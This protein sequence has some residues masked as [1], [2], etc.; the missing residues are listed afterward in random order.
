MCAE[1]RV[2]AKEFSELLEALEAL[3]NHERALEGLLSASDLIQEAAYAYAHEIDGEQ[4]VNL[5]LLADS[6]ER[7]AN[8]LKKKR[9]DIACI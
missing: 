8:R 9:K 3:P 7:E 1:R 6:V 4:I 5:I 2:T